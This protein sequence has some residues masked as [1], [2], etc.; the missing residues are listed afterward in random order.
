MILQGLYILNSYNINCG[1][2]WKLVTEGLPVLLEC[3][4]LEGTVV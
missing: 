1:T 2:K 4:V 3:T